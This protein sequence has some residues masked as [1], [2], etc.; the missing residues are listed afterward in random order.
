M[1][2]AIRNKYDCFDYLTPRELEQ[3]TEIVTEAFIR[4]T[5]IQPEIFEIETNIIVDTILEVD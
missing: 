2:T 1:T 4:E 5:K 3:V